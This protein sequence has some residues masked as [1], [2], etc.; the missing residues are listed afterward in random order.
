M[1]SEDKESHNLHQW[2]KLSI[3]LKKY[4]YLY[5]EKRLTICQTLLVYFQRLQ[6]VF[7]NS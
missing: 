1:N 3:L 6:S 4:M 5:N 7:R 2:I